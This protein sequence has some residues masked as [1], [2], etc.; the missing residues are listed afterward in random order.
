M[1]GQI[2]RNGMGCLSGLGHT[3][4]R[5]LHLGLGDG[6]A[7]AIPQHQSVGYHTKDRQEPAGCLP[8]RPPRPA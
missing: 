8:L 3:D 6:Q 4:V 2:G 5:V 1:W 7:L